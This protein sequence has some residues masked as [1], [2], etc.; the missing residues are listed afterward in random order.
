M[1]TVPRNY[2][3]SLHPFEAAR[4]YTRALNAV[5][6][7]KIF[8]K[9]FLKNLEGHRDAISCICKHPFQLSVLLSGAY[10]GEVRTWNL[11]L[12][13]STRSFLA[14]D[15]VLR[16]ITYIPD[17][18][19]FITVGDDKTIKTWSAAKEENEPLNTIISK[20]CNVCI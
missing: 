9:P 15:G 14:H 12:E 4:E 7:D 1:F 13:K 11:A 5:K 2:D 10:D 6:L 19:H 8:A 18:E 17:G 16:G 20:V 3:P